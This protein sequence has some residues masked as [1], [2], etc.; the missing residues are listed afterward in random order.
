MQ[1]VAIGLVDKSW[2][3]EGAMGKALFK[4]ILACWWGMPGVL[5]EGHAEGFVG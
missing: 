1:A 4:G 5:L 2:L 3:D